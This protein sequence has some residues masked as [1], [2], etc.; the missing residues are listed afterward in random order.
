VWIRIQR[1]DFVPLARI[2]GAAATEREDGFLDQDLSDDL[3]AILR[4]M[5]SDRAAGRRFASIVD[6]TGAPALNAKQRA[7][8][9]AWVKETRELTRLTTI[10]TVFVAPSALLRG[11]LTAIFWT[12]SFGVPNRVL[13]TLND[14]VTWSLERILDT[15]LPVAPGTDQAA[16]RAFS[17]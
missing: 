3:A 7:V 15:G 1:L 2:S 17:R 5:Q 11:A 14:A 10:S 13:G 9:S 16:L 6:L 12:Q 8:V 4:E